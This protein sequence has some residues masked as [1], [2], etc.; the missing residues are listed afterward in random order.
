MLNSRKLKLQ[1]SVR[2]GKNEMVA[3]ASSENTP[4]I[5]IERTDKTISEKDSATDC[6]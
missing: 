3:F 6:H 2:N 4:M 1:V 5:I